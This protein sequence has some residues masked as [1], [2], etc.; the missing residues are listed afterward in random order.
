MKLR[1][2]AKY[3]DN[4]SVYDAYTGALLFKAQFSTF[5]SSDPDGSF[6]RRRT[7]SVAPDTVPASRRAV[8]VG[9]NYWIMGEL[10]A[11]AFKDRPIRA[12][13]SAKEVTGLYTLLTPGQAASKSATGLLQVYG[14]L[15]H[16]KDTVNTPT[17]SSYN[18]QYEMT[19]GITEAVQPGLFVRLY[20]QLFHTRS[21]HRAVEGFWV[22]TVDQ[23]AGAYGG[24]EVQ[25]IF[26]G[27]YDPVTETYATGTAVDGILIDMYKLYN[28]TTAADD[29]NRPG[30][31]SL[32]VAKTTTPV[33][34]QPIEVDGV[35]YQNTRFTSYL[36]AWNIHLRRL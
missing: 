5:E 26:A 16:L 36:D 34:G 24:G 28:Y 30:D 33:I 25:A 22:A 3:F 10:V 31:L 1:N 27:T 15:N 18:P 6:Q 2:A 8:K 7:V 12:S 35:Q 17:N 29:R 20:N 11:E 4:D 9:D 14:H 13:A 32:I 19:L 21:V 23:V